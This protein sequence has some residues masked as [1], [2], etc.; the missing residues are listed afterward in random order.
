MIQ[1]YSIVS[2]MRRMRSGLK[3]PRKSMQ[4][5][6]EILASTAR[7]FRCM[8]SREAWPNESMSL[9]IELATKWC[10]VGNLSFKVVRT[11]TT[12]ENLICRNRRPNFAARQVSCCVRRGVLGESLCYWWEVI[13]SPSLR[14][15]NRGN[16]IQ[17]FSGL[18]RSICNCRLVKQKF[19][20]VHLGFTTNC[21]QLPILRIAP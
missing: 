3:R 14:L 10:S 9:S 6:N 7:S 8:L 19:R 17:S 15:T 4:K 21:I 13:F 5:T 12:N 1:V 2:Q 18:I 20:M 16:R 11:K